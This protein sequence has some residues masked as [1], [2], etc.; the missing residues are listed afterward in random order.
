MTQQLTQTIHGNVRDEITQSPLIGATVR[1]LNIDPMIGAIADLE[2]NFMISEVP[3]G[4]HNLEVTFVGYEPVMIPEI[5]VTSGKSVQLNIEMKEM[6][7]YLDVLFHLLF[8]PRAN[9]I[10]EIHRSRY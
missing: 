2:G 3:I 9:Q 8:R 1:I 10:R 6:N 7:T 4:R 5:L